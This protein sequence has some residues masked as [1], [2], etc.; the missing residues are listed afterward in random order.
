MPYAQYNTVSTDPLP[1]GI[2]ISDEQYQ[3]AIEGMVLGKVVSV[4]GGFSVGWPPPPEEVPPTV[5][6]LRVSALAQRDRL[7]S[8][9][10]ARMAPYQDA[11]DLDAATDHER[12]TL[13]AWKLHRVELNRIEQQS[14]FPEQV[15]W[16]PSPDAIATSS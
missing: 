7:L 12:T 14:G 13:K 11:V 10:T 5:E 15:E 8:L 2:E 6:E 1:G 9:A 3:E 4:E 16:P